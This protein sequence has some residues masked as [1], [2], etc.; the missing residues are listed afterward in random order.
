VTFDNSW[1]DPVA[2]H[3]RAVILDKTQVAHVTYTVSPAEFYWIQSA[4]LMAS[5]PHTEAPS[6]IGIKATLLFFYRKCKADRI[7]TGSNKAEGKPPVDASLV[8]GLYVADIVNL[9][10]GDAMQGF[11]TFLNMNLWD[12]IQYKRACWNILNEVGYDI[13]KAHGELADIG[14]QIYKT[15]H[16]ENIFT[17]W[18]QGYRYFKFKID[19][20]RWE[21]N[22]DGTYDLSRPPYSYDEFLELSKQVSDRL[23]E[24]VLQYMV[25]PI[26]DW[27]KYKSYRK[28]LNKLRFWR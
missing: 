1:D 25:H 27:R 28:I 7:V 6:D 11:K 18:N 14:C 13:P 22:S 24:N 12:H 23:G 10:G 2:A 4:M 26:E 3:K 19:A 16:Y 20:R 17:R 5:T 9:F 8:D 21:E 15:K